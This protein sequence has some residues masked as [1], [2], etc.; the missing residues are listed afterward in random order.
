MK[1]RRLGFIAVALGLLLSGAVYVWAY[2][3]MVHPD[4]VKVGLDEQGRFQT[5]AEY[6]L[7]GEVARHLFA[8]VHA[9]DRRVRPEVWTPTAEQFMQSIENSLVDD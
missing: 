2:A 9:I 5:W 4:S 7:G 1:K 8:P 3:S 6:P